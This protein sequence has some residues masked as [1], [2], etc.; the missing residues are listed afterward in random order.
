[1][2]I[3]RLR[4]EHDV[5]LE[6]LIQ[7]RKLTHEGIVDNAPSISRG[8]EQLGDFVIKHLAVE[9]RTLYPTLKASASAEL[10]TLSDKYEQEMV[11]LSAPFINFVRRW[12]KSRELMLNPLEFR[13]EAN[14][15][16][17]A[18]FERIKQENSHFYPAVER[19][20]KH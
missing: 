15:V 10:R 1:M 4:D 6:K 9:N 8:I 11:S 12:S 16:L 3:S 7:L 14:T 18:L 20:L 13:E 17:R 2:N 5:I 19:N